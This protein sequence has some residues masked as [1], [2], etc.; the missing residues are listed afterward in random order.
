MPQRS[1]IPRVAFFSVPTYQMDLVRAENL[2][3]FSLFL[4]HSNS[5]HWIEDLEN[6]AQKSFIVRSDGKFLVGEDTLAARLFSVWDL[7]NRRVEQRYFSSFLR[8]FLL[9]EG[10]SRK[11]RPTTFSLH[12]LILLY[13]CLF[14]GSGNDNVGYPRQ[15]GLSLFW[16]RRAE[17]SFVKSRER[18]EQDCVKDWRF[19]YV[20]QY[21]L[22]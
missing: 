21:W 16:R 11:S 6:T 7:I 13:H 20:I 19:S 9:K 4:P 15:D 14:S 17:S 12:F 10:K 8:D 1:L 18:S 22:S 3:L 2:H 5:V